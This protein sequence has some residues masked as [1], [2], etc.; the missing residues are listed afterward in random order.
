M[1]VEP[2]VDAATAKVQAWTYAQKLLFRRGERTDLDLDLTSNKRALVKAGKIMRRQRNARDLH[3]ITDL[4]LLLFDNYL[5]SSGT[6]HSSPFHA[7]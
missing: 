1:F 4:F 3:G 6:F 2:G 7:H 5:R